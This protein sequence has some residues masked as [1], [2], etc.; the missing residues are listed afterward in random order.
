MTAS[1]HFSETYQEAQ[2]R[3]LDAARSQEA[4]VTAYHNPHGTGPNGEPLVLHTAWIGPRDAT[5]VLLNLSGTHGAEGFP[6]SAAQTL[7]LTHR[8]AASLPAGTAA[9]FIHAVNPFGF[10]W[11]LRGTENNVDLNRNWL[12]HS[13]PLPENPL[14]DA[15]HDLLCPKS[16]DDKA[17]Q[18]LMARGADLIEKHGQWALED[19]ISRGQ[20]THPDGFHF[21]GHATEWSTRTLQEIVGKELAGAR[22]VAF[23]DWHSGPVGN[24]ELIFLCFSDPQSA[25]FGRAADWWG[26]RN[27]DPSTV[28][29]LWGS[30]RPTRRGIVFWGVEQAL[31]PH[32]EMTG[33]V[34]E[35]RSASPKPNPALALRASMLERWLRF[36]G[37]LDAPESAAFRE[38]IRADYAPRRR[39][40]EETVTQNALLVYDQTLAGMAH[41]AAGAPAQSA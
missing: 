8:G 19:A 4:E 35:F 7:W 20:Y 26:R 12:D 36:E 38:E 25:A 17:M 14:Y 11:M 15:V 6:G 10:A 30:K 34:I 37:G 40:W 18:L 2:Q 22:R 16:L 32:A 28:D 23:I 39:S 1:R 41:W 9:L 13:E 27:L 24:G 5:T 33:A 3:F 21:G 31:Q 29:R